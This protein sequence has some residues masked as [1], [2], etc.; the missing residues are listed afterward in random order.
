MQR[1]APRLILIGLAS[2][3]T[4]LAAD[5]HAQSTFELPPMSDNAALQ[6]WQASATMPALDAKQEKLLENWAE[7]PLGVATSKLL[8]QSQTSLKFLRRAAR[9]QNCDWGLDYSEGI[10]MHLPH[11]A[12]ARTLARLAALDARRA[13]ATG[14]TEV[15]G[16]D[17]FSILAM[18]HQVGRDYTLVSMLVCYA[19]EGMVVD[20]VAPHLPELGIPYEDAMKA[21]ESLPPGPRLEHSVMCE[22]RLAQSI[23][24]QLQEAEKQRPGS[25]RETWNAMASPE[26]PEALKRVESLEEVVKMAEDF[27]SVYDELAH[28][29]VLPPQEFDAK[30]PEF[31]KRASA[32]NPIAEL[33]LPAMDKVI[34]TQRRSE[35]R[36]AMLMAAIAVVEGGPEKLA[37][38]KDPFGDGPF[39]YCKLD[40]GFEL[41]SK[42][43]HEGQPVTLVIGRE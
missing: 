35:A 5:V 6:Y 43:V 33:L 25:W 19:M 29:V 23:I 22:K 18:A 8:D 31:A 11:L 17:M 2:A 40:D 39:E 14:N 15:A 34:A 10:S 4:L 37:D 3:A 20:L 13:L 16:E 41:K 7:T 28:L 24:V 42:L 30:Y 1:L 9:L 27:Q 36:M 12:K 21:F 38:I 26:M 32:A